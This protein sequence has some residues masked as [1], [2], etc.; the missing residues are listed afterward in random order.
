ML[1]QG[2]QMRLQFVQ[3]YRFTDWRTVANDVEIGLAKVDDPFTS[4]V[5][6]IGVSDVPLLR[7]GPVKHGRPARNL[8]NS[9]G[10]LPL[11]ALECRSDTIPGNAQM[12]K[13]E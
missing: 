5:F 11:N 13:A 4:G 1:R 9:E 7:H 12:G 3:R 8:M 6:N 10:N 2:K